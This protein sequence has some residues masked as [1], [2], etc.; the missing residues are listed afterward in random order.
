MKIYNLFNIA[1]FSSFLIYFA[2]NNK[3]EVKPKPNPVDT[4]K[5]PVDTTKK[6]VDL[7]SL[8]TDSIFKEAVSLI[9]DDN[10]IVNELNDILGF[11][12]EIM[13]LGAVNFG[14]IAF[15]FDG[16]VN[17]TVNPRTDTTNGIV[18]L[19]FGNGC[20][21]SK[22]DRIRKGKVV[23]T[24][25]KKLHQKTAVLTTSFENYMVKRFNNF[26]SVML[27][28]SSSI[29]TTHVD[30]NQNGMILERQVNI[31]LKFGDGTKI[32]NQGRNDITAKVEAISDKFD[33]SYIQKQG[34]SLSGIDR[35][36]KSFKRTVISDLLTKGSCQ[37]YSDYKPV[38]GK[39]AFEIDGKSILI[40]YGNGTCD[41]EVSITINGKTKKTNW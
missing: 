35:K 20:R 5:N 6:P 28:N 17:V 10:Q 39:E 25:S 22:D 14:R 21:A 23:W 16:C 38:S 41:G 34:N 8:K 7:D 13:T 4:T 9:R 32:S 19:D 15:K 31:I 2:C 26:D 30:S 33:N 40:D 36:G 27:D 37:F 29:T 3:D 18:I 1:I 24:Y 11:Q 12:D